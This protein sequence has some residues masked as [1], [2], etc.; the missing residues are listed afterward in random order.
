MGFNSRDYCEQLAGKVAD[1][2]EGRPGNI[3]GNLHGRSRGD[4]MTA[5]MC[6]AE[7]SF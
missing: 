6:N 1:V 7:A 4:G 5:P 2:Y 3:A